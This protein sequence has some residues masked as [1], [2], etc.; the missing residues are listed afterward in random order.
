M[1]TIIVPIYKV[2][3]YLQRCIESIL[4]QTYCDFELLLVNDGS[5]DKCGNIC[6]EYA[7]KD[8]RIKVFHKTNGGVGS[9][10]NY[11]LNNASGEWILFVDGDD[12]LLPNSLRYFIEKSKFFDFIIAGYETIDS[13]GLEK[14]YNLPDKKFFKQ[15]VLSS[16]LWHYPIGYQGYLWNKFFKRKIIEQ[17]SIRFNESFAFNEDRLFCVQYVSRLTSPTCLIDKKV[18]L[19]HLNDSSA[20]GSLLFGFN[21]KFFTDF[22]AQLEIHKIILSCGN[23]INVYDSQYTLYKSYRRIKKMILKFNVIENDIICQ[24]KAMRELLF[25]HISKKRL[26]LFHL[27]KSVRKLYRSIL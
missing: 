19:Y 26:F 7:Q 25:S 24:I 18:Y 3:Q 4:S 12:E 1:I 14:S 21:P 17:Y 9:A 20:I 2:E 22:Y 10:R 5:P 6:D 8:S 13:K 11:G 23:N 27:P 16:F 15:D